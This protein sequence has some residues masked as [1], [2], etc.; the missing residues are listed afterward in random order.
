MSDV[1]VA[2][3]RARA[4]TSTGNQDIT[5]AD[6]GGD[7]PK[8]VVFIVTLHG[9]T[10]G[11]E[12]AQFGMGMGMAISA[13]ERYSWTLRSQDSVGTSW[14]KRANRSDACCLL[15]TSNTGV[16]NPNYE[17]DFVAFI[18]NGVRINWSAVDS[19]ANCSVTAIFFAGAD[20]AVDWV[21]FSPN[22]TEDAATAITS[23]DFEA[24]V[25]FTMSALQGLGTDDD[26]GKCTVGVITN[27]ET[28]VHQFCT[29]FQDDHNVGTS[30][31]GGVFT[32]DGGSHHIGGSGPPALDYRLEYGA[33][34]SSGFDVTTREDTGS[35]SHVHAV[36]AL[37]LPSDV[38]AQVG[39]VTWPSSTGVASFTNGRAF[40][41]Q[42]A[43][44]GMFRGPTADSIE[45]GG[46]ATG[47][48]GVC[49]ATAE[50]SNMARSEDAVATT[51]T[52]SLVDDQV[53]NLP[54]DLG[55]NSVDYIGAFDSF[56]S[57]GVNINFSE[58][59]GATQAVGWMLNI[60]EAVA[61]AA[62]AGP[63]VNARRLKSKL[64]GL[65][66]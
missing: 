11:T 5:T 6:L 53:I 1:K 54:P 8:A 59:R 2:I 25:L 52:A 44:F 20:L 46:R 62:H 57:D 9:G 28:N 51:N 27:D 15:M 32:T 7:T 58:V 3:A 47:G 37:N 16:P 48:W 17:A 14:T 10:L 12:V 45:T 31:Q 42:F 63:L 38:D 66:P 34:D 21:T 60:E 19:G 18:S 55:P 26:P 13:T 35:A 4:N 33:F 39:Q 43:M 49:T 64:Q 65:V 29:N 50:F 41:P 56:D 22:A 24:N 30:S 23:L 40:K 36:L 61:V